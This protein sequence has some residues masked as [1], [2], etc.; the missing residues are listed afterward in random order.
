MGWSQVELAV[1]A[2]VSATTVYKAEKG[3]PPGR[4]T[5]RKLAAALGLEPDQ[6][7]ELRQPGPA[8]SAGGASAGG[9]DEG[10]ESQ[11]RAV[12]APEGG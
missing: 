9:A 3:H 6:I 10:P 4:T 11:T 8:K 1:R 12:P 2:G 5:A 7:A